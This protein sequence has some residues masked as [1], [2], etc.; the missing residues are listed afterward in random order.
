MGTKYYTPEEIHYEIAGMVTHNDDL[1]NLLAVILTQVPSEIVDNIFENCL[2]LMPDPEE[3]G[4]FI[5]NRI[6]GERHIILFPYSLLEESLKEQTKTV[7]HE[8]A[9]YVLKHESPLEWDPLEPECTDNK[10]DKQ[11]KEACSL[12]EYWLNCKDSHTRGAD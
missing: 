7:L 9:H 12:V 2:F 5:P 4:S 1:R 3:K 8:I 10:Y 6:I 11:E